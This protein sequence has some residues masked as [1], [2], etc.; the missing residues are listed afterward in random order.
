MAGTAGSV[1]EACSVIADTKPDLLFLDIRL[2]GENGFD[3]LEKLD[4]PT[5]GVIFVT[6]Y[7]QYGIR[8][9]KF[10]ALDYLLKPLD[11]AELQLAVQ[12]AQEKLLRKQTAPD[13]GP[14]IDYL[15]RVPSDRQRIALPLQQE[16]RYVGISAIIRCEAD[17]TYTWFYLEN[18]EKIL[19]SG[20]LKEYAELLSPFGFLRT[21]QS[22]VINPAFVK[23]WLKEDGGTLL[24]TDQTKIPVSKPNREK[25]KA[26]L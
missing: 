1:R 19:V 11:I 13:F 20:V 24:L 25:V 12:K 5:F 6:A 21:H 15:K 2:A 8:A 9:V 22:H 23:S 26:A 14:V 17:N 18:S 10:G 3:L 4:R 7:D 16:T